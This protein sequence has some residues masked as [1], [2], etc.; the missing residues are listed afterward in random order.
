[1]LPKKAPINH[2]GIAGGIGF[3]VGICPAMPNG[4][5]KLTGTT[6][7]K[8]D[9]YGNYQYVDGSVMC[10]IPAFYYKYGTGEN[11]LAINAVDIKAY[12]FFTDVA[13][14]NTV[15]YALHRAFY[16][17]GAIQPGVFADK[18]LCS[19]NGGIA[20]SIKMGLPL[21]SAATHNPFG[22]LNGAPANFYYG[23]IAAAKTRGE[24]F[25]CN[26]RFIFSALALL[27]L[28]HGQASTSTATCAWY[29]AAG[30]KNFPKG[31]NNNALG[32]ANDPS[33][34]FISDGYLNCAK[35]GSA[36]FLAKTAH[37]G[38]ASGVVDLNGNLYE[39]SLGITADASNYYL[40][41]TSVN[42][43]AL[44][45]G[46]T[47]ATDA[48]GSAGI[49]A[50]YDSLGANYEALTA[51]STVKL[52]GAASQV[53]TE[54]TSGL[55]WAAAN[56]GI[57][58]LGGTGGT[59]LFGNDALYDYRPNELCPRAGGSWSSGSGAGVWLL[60][61]NGVR[62]HSDTAVGVRAALYLD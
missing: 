21:S 2:I 41:K 31:T 45:A 10:W 7:P 27:S 36:N 47:L 44:T 46:N 53:F 8:H 25:F 33:L 54:A 4:F 15:G 5:S 43:A 16:N 11:G 39:I 32:D 23:A 55:A 26:S 60:A 24:K 50:Q 17:A 34:T 28:A 18:Y 61:L 40:L 51:S 9:N 29:D 56:A 37:N 19:N 38:Q 30:V 42:M 48:W 52:V 49:A 12:D 62:G 14:A 57:P 20:S 59:N 13:S 22:G 3:G 35:T 1:M 6:K 58:L